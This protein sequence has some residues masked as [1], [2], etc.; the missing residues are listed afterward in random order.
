MKKLLTVAVASCF[1][2]ACNGGGGGSSG[3]NNNDDPVNPSITNPD[4][5]A[6]P[7][8]NLQ[9][10]KF[11]QF[12][13][14]KNNTFKAGIPTLKIGGHQ[15]WYLKITN[16]N[17]VPIQFVTGYKDNR[18]PLEV[19]VP[20]QRQSGFLHEY[21]DGTQTCGSYGCGD[22]NSINPA[23]SASN[24]AGLY[25]SIYANG[26]LGY[27]L[28]NPESGYTAY[29]IENHGMNNGLLDNNQ[30]ENISGYK[31]CLPSI[32]GNVTELAPNEA[33]VVRYNAQFNGQ[34]YSE[35]DLLK[36]SYDYAYK[37]VESGYNI[38]RTLAPQYLNDTCEGNEVI[39]SYFIATHT[40]GVCN[41]EQ[42]PKNTFDFQP[43]LNHENLTCRHWDIQVKCYDDGSMSPT[44]YVKEY[45]Y[46][47]TSLTSPVKMFSASGGEY[48]YHYEA[49][50]G[51]NGY[52]NNWY[53]GYL[54]GAGSP[55]INPVFNKNGSLIIWGYDYGK[56]LYGISMNYNSANNTVEK[57]YNR[58]ADKNIDPKTLIDGQDFGLRPSQYMAMALSDSGKYFYTDTNYRQVY[59]IG[60]TTFLSES[61]MIA[62]FTNTSFEGN[63]DIKTSYAQGLNGK[64][65][66]SICYDSTANQSYGESPNYCEVYRMNNDTDN[67]PTATLISRFYAD[68]TYNPVKR[69]LLLTGVSA[70]ETKFAFQGF[71]DI[72]HNGGYYQRVVCGEVN[73]LPNKYDLTMRNF[74]PRLINGEYYSQYNL[75]NWSSDISSALGYAKFDI[76]TCSLDKTK[77]VTG[78]IGI[79][80][81][82]YGIR[83]VSVMG[84]NADTGVGMYSAVAPLTAYSNG[85]SGE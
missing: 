78:F 3:G 14:D 80:T 18:N 83:P 2:V 49:L 82:S 26:Y 32:D 12:V 58:L 60:N 10:L 53:S 25:S 27:T 67:V 70:D 37:A 15:F 6:K 33:C 71:F 77:Y 44:L 64:L 79:L 23:T 47:S 31:Y 52:L 81:N 39:Q 74:S 40:K 38:N 35:S 7:D 72:D 24:G 73:Q 48:W 51:Y 21:F 5:K 65:Y 76:N 69:G 16:T 30:F 57:S 61:H 28:P 66:F 20:Q 11:E 1:I 43:L 84:D 68:P 75:S 41:Q 54:N 34:N 45:N 9:P 85:L 17:S 62:P 22:G 8:L 46:S 56:S 55:T 42:T 29:L 13:V 63:V 50:G 4:S 19:F 59:K 36:F